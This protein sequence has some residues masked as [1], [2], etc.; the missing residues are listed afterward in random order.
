MLP[1][2]MICGVVTACALFGSAPALAQVT[3]S[4]IYNLNGTLSDSLGG[5]SLTTVGSATV[6]ASGVS[7]TTAGSGL[8]LSSSAFAN[9]GD[10]AIQM[11]F[12]IDTPGWWSRLINSNGGDNG[13]YGYF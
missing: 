13:L 8:S 4:H 10:Y 9:S 3:A 7:Y 11:V 1:R 5:P 2:G 12:Q 6:G